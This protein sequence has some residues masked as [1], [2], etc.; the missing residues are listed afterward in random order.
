MAMSDARSDAESD[1]SPA[2]DIV[3]LGS[4]FTYTIL[5]FSAITVNLRHAVV[6]G[7]VGSVN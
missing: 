1:V 7:L 3:G 2:V 4:S 6:Q 5:S